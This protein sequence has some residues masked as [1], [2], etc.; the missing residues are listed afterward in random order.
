MFQFRNYG[1]KLK[2]NWTTTSNGADFG[3]DYYTR[4][5]AAKSNIFINKS[6]E[7]KYFYQDLDSN[8]DRLNG[9]NNY[10]V[11]FPKGQIPPVNGFWSLT[12]Y[13]S[14]HFFAPNEINKYSLG[15]KNQDLKYNKDGSLTLYVQSAKP[16]KDKESNWLP[17]PKNGDFSLYLRA[18][19][20]K[21]EISDGK[22]TP[23]AVT[24]VK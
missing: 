21:P 3:T 6:K 22:W 17:S 2:Y 9:N 1:Q 20:P 14:E 24:K 11:T 19:W 23:P 16:S 10:T 18:Y 13:N 12:L 7:T 8:S 5:A 4:T 15:T